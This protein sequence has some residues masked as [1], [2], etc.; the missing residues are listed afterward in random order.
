MN[1]AVREVMRDNAGYAE[2]EVNDG[3]VLDVVRDGRAFLSDMSRLIDR[4]VLSSRTGEES[5]AAGLFLDL[6]AGLETL[7]RTIEVL[8]AAFGSDFAALDYKG[9]RIELHIRELNDVLAEILTAQ[10]RN[11]WILI[12]D[13]MEYELRCRIAIWGEI[14]H[15][16]ET[17]LSREEDGI[18]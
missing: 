6:L 3:L 8:D 9:G 2:Y 15:M 10:E 17:G 11:D 4:V 5:A 7:L 12:G 13:L 16:L 1:Q 14:F 18:I